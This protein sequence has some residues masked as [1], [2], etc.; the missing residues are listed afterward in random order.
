MSNY[1]FKFSC[2][3]TSDFM[4]GKGKRCITEVLYEAKFYKL[5]FRY[6]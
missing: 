4:V 1:L 2:K 3:L 6:K 5:Q